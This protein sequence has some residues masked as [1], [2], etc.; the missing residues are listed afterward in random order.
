MSRLNFDINSLAHETLEL[1]KNLRAEN[2]F[3]GEEDTFDFSFDEIQEQ[4]EVNLSSEEIVEEIPIEVPDSCGVLYYL[5]KG[6]STFCVRGVVSDD[7]SWDQE[8]LRRND[9]Q[10]IKA[11]RLREDWE[12]EEIG[13]FPTQSLELAETVCDQMINRRFPRNEAVLC[14]LSDPG[15]SWWM[16]TDLRSLDIFFQSHGIERD[17]S[18]I[19][20]GPLGDPLISF[21]RFS[22]SQGI[23]KNLFSINEFSSTEKAFSLTTSVPND[24]FEMFQRVFTDG[25]FE[26]DDILGDL[27]GEEQTFFLFLKE[28]ACLRAFWLGILD[29]L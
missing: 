22:R 24:F 17:S 21:K 26:F 2:L 5:E 6:I 1:T 3:D 12:M 4:N 10:L 7:L 23:L 25:A 18:L 28:I 13:F 15:F 14:N 8:A 16:Q 11:L 29:Q 19:Q 27:V 20:L 9:P